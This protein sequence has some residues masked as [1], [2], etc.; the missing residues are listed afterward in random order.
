[1]G[2]LACDRHQCDNIM[3]DR[4]SHEFGY[5]CN[6]CFAELLEANSVGFYKFMQ[7][8]PGTFGGSE[9]HRRNCESE[10]QPR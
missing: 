10:F 2:V 8:N 5:L 7:T 1:M 3:C 9:I 6:T 4:Y